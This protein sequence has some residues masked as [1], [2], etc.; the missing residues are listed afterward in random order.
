[1]L[2]T[3]WW[4]MQSSSDPRKLVPRSAMYIA[5]NRL[6]LPVPFGPTITVPVSPSCVSNNSY[7]RKLYNF[8][9]EIIIHIVSWAG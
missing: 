8:N 1:M 6:V 2:C 7:E 9:L 4:R 5:S 3:V